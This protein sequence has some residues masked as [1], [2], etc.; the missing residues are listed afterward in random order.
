[1]ISNILDWV[2]KTI[3]VGN[4]ISLYFFSLKYFT[5]KFSSFLIIEL[6]PEITTFDADSFS[7]P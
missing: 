6:S 2:D 4:N 3:K 7:N 5:G 1:M